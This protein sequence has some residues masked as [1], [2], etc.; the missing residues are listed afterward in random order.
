MVFREKREREKSER[1]KDGSKKER[2]ELSKPL[3]FLLGEVIICIDLSLQVFFFSFSAGPP[4]N[5]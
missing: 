5:P 4:C 2:R 3:G 1:E